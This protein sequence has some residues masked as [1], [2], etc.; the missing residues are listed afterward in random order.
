MSTA[1]RPRPARGH[2]RPRAVGPLAAL[3]LLAALALAPSAAAKAGERTFQETFPKASALCA[4]VA[5]GGGPAR[6]RS[7]AGQ[8]GADCKTL[9]EGFESAH[10]QV[11]AAQSSFATSLEADRSAIASAC[12]PPVADRHLCRRTR[13][14][15]RRAIRSLRREHRAAVLLYFTTIE[16]DRRTFWAAIHALPGGAHIP[17]DKPVRP[18]SS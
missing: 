13:V 16:S 12:T 4:E 18:E 17:A 5:A 1:S 6:L 8:V 9:E 3:P 7:H 15:E 11:A 2:R 14:A 10:D